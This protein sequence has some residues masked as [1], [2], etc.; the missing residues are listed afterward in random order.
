MPGRHNMGHDHGLR[1]AI[2]HILKTYRTRLGISQAALAKQLGISQPYLSRL[3]REQRSAVSLSLWN[4]V[5]QLID[6]PELYIIDDL[7]DDLDEI[8]DRALIC[9]G[10]GDLETAEALFE[11]VASGDPS[12]SAF[13]A[14]LVAKAKFQLAGIRRDRNELSGE[15]GAEALYSDALRWYRARNSKRRITETLFVMGACREMSKDHRTALKIY[16]DLLDEAD[17]TG[18]RIRVRLNGRIGAL[19][20]KLN[21]YDRANDCLDAAIRLAV[22]LDESAPYSYYREKLAILQ[23]RQGRLDEAYS[24]LLAARREIQPTEH[25]RRVQSCCAEDNTRLPQR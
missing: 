10:G 11:T 14:D 13:A 7:A 25:L 18:T 8:Y 17:D 22:H 12:T 2:G 6:R 3:E 16:Q 5:S 9:Y 1:L 19:T 15:F 20:T 21:Q 24:S 23:T 4:K